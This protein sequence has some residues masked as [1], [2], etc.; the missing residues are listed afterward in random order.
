MEPYGSSSVRLDRENVSITHI[1]HLEKKTK[2]KRK[3]KL[4]QMSLTGVGS[5][6]FIINR[7][8]AEVIGKDRL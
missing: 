1:P 4:A 5:R 8:I 3:E 6:F 7:A 2:K